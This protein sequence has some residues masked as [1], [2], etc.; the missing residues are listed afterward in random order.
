MRPRAR[1]GALLVA[2]FLGPVTL[3]ACDRA[4]SGASLKEWSA[5]DH[6]GEKK[7]GGPTGKQGARGASDAGGAAMLVEATWQSQCATCHG[8]GGHGDGPQGPMVR[9]EDLSKDAWQA[10][11]DDA[12][13][14]ASIR[15]GKGKMPK[16]D[17][18]PDEVVKGLV[19]RVRSFRGR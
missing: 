13:I 6:D 1:L 4:P 5:A 15:N 2:A 10:G 18:L 12:Q 16:F 7:T 8:P 19:A 11:I 14:E 17:K 9:A 3:L